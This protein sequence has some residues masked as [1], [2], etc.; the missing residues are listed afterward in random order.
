[1]TALFEEDTVAVQWSNILH[2]TSPDSPLSALT[3]EQVGQEAALQPWILKI[4]ERHPWN[5][6][7]WFTEL[8]LLRPAAT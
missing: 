5:Q 3:E 8:E 7:W 2:A 4:P 6:R 1:M